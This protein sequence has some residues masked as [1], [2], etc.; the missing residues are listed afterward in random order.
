M[1]V[2]DAINWQYTVKYSKQLTL[3]TAM[4]IIAMILAA[5]FSY[6]NKPFVFTNLQLGEYSVFSYWNYLELILVAQ[7]LPNIFL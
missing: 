2:Y 3:H 4:C 1:I 7:K 6:M 5:N